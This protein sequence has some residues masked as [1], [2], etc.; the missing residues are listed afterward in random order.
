MQEALRGRVSQQAVR[1]FVVVTEEGVQVN[2]VFRAL[3]PAG[4]RRAEWT[5]RSCWW[6]DEPVR[7]ITVYWPG[8]PRTRTSL[9]A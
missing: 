9:S 4:R 8:T 2:S 7:S 6:A 5:L 3:V 1:G